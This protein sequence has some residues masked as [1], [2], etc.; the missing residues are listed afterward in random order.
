MSGRVSET[1]LAQRREHTEQWAGFLAIMN[2]SHTILAERK[3]GDARVAR[4]WE[5]RREREAAASAGGW[6]G[7]L[8]RTLGGS[9][10]G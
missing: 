2:Q 8:G 7:W 3:I 9:K 4:Y 1:D 6:P 10:G 5:R